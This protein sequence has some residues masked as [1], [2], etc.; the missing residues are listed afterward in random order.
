VYNIVERDWSSPRVEGTYAFGAVGTS[1]EGT[2]TATRYLAE[3][4]G[5]YDPIRTDRQKLSITAGASAEYN[6]AERVFLTGEGF[7]SDVFQY[8]GN[9]GKITAYDAYPEAHNLLSVFSRANYALADRYFLTGSLRTDGSSRFARDTRWGVFPSASIGWRISEEPMLAALKNV[10]DT[11]LRLSWGMT[12]NQAISTNTGFLTT[13]GRANYAGEPGLAAS[14]RLGNPRLRWESTR[15]VDIGADLGFFDGRISVIADYYQKLTSDLLVSRPISSTSGY[16][17]ILDNVGS[18]E[19]RGYELQVTTENVTSAAKNGFSWKSDF[20][21]SHNRNKVRELYRNEPFVSGIRSVNRVQ[22]GHPIGSFY[23]LKFTGVNQQTGVAEYED[24][25]GPKGA[26]GKPTGPDGKI[27]ADDRQIVGSPHPD[28][29]GGLRNQFT[30]MGF[31]LNTFVE[32]S[33]GQEV[34]NLIR[35]FSDDGGYNLDNKITHVL[36]RWQKPGDVTD[37]PRASFD[38]ASEANDVSSRFVEDGSYVRLSEI[39]VGY[40][41][42]PALAQRARFDNARLYVSGRNLKLWTK[43]LGY[44]PDVNSNGSGA[45][46][47]L[48][49]DF[50][51]YP[52]ARTISVGISGTW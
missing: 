25:A 26:D 7:G 51:A 38:G 37:V 9:A 22:V 3:T 34:F 47:S 23:T 45:N 24:I 30:W 52:R 40:A 43:Y 13:F 2:S 50:Y 17:T 32:F 8:P 5:S 14:A 12:G 19:N 18:I 15:E 11:K 1:T 31:D 48:G 42:P 16:T 49:Q 33:Q 6:R 28:Y 36:K 21:I 29:F 35:L 20:N 41:L 4:F 39:T 27:T 44:D 10:A 46:T